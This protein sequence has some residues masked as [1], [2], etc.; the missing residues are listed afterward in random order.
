MNRIGEIRLIFG[1]AACQSTCS[2]DALKRP[3]VSSTT[4][5]ISPRVGFADC[6]WR[7]PTLKL[8]DWALSGE[9]SISASR[10]STGFSGTGGLQM[11]NC[12]SKRFV[13]A[14]RSSE[15]AAD[16]YYFHVRAEFPDGGCHGFHVC[17]VLFL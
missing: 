9:S 8:V 1:W 12:G 17:A 5:S 16:S 7:S 6:Q 13:S 10:S 4:D 11:I 3:L 2:R 14:S 15:L